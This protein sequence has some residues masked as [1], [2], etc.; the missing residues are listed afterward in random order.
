VIR[1]VQAAMLPKSSQVQVAEV[2]LG[3]LLRP[4][5]GQTGSVEEWVYEFVDAGIRK[6]LL[7][8]VPVSS[9]VRVLSRYIEKQFD[10][11]LKAFIAELQ[12][13]LSEGDALEALEPFA[14]VAADVLRRK[15]KEYEGFIQTVDR[16]YPEH[17]SNP[18]L[19]EDDLKEFA[20]EYGEYEEVAPTPQLQTFEFDILTFATERLE[21]TEPD[22]LAALD[23]QRVAFTV[24]TI[25]PN[26]KRK[27]LTS[28]RVAWTYTAEAES[29]RKGPIVQF[30]M[31]AIPGGEFSMGSDSEKP[32][33]PVKVPPFFMGKYPV[34]QKLWSAVAQM[35]RVNR[36]LERDP[37][38]FKSDDQPVERA[39]W[40]DAMEFCARLSK[41][42]GREYR[43]PTEAEWE[44][45]CRAETTTEYHFGDAITNELANYGGANSGTTPIGQFPYVNA[46]GL[47][48]MHG[49]VWEWCMD[50]WHESYKG[51]PSDG[52]AWIDAKAKEDAPRVLRGGSWN[53]NPAHCRSASRYRNNAA[54]RYSSIGFRLVSPARILL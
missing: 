37:A 16:Y 41:N 18:V 5:L 54:F 49:N 4:Q 39:F 7:K 23:W 2:L 1:L 35:P 6:E 15:G 30:E 31:M 34:T 19:V 26:Q 20:F 12:S 42:M 45:A 38:K 32:I 28:D 53:L 48:D 50:H 14:I 8:D 11:S 29:T 25:A 52:S 24:A 9:T 27:L 22:P 43:L 21:N 36:D 3:G 17:V 47:S 10:V 40:L 13:E 51:T 33:H 46:F 44:Y